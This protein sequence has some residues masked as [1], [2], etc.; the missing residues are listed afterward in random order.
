ML[1]DMLQVCDRAI[2]T[3]PK[4]DRSL[5]PEILSDVAGK[6]IRDVKIIPSVGEAVEYAIETAAPDELICIAGSLYV[7]GEA[8]EEL[9]KKGLT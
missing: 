8:K 6:I 4:I 9:E 7:V 3:R 2:I 1:R 5:K